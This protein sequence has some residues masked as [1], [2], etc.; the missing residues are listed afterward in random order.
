[1]KKISKRWKIYGILYFTAV[2]ALV[3]ALAFAYIDPSVTT[4]AIQAFAGVAVA[5]GAFF[6]TYG[7]RMKKSWMRTVN[8]DPNDTR[9]TEA[10]LEV[11]R[12]DLQAALAAKRQAKAQDPPAEVK[13]GKKQGNLGGRI[14]TSL[15]CGI[16][17]ALAVILRPMVSFYLSN[18]REFWF[19][20]TDVMPN[21]LLLFFGA[22]AAAAVIHFLLPDGKKL[23]F[24][25]LFAVLAAAGTLCAFVQDHFMSSYLPTLTGDEIDWSI[26]GTWNLLSIGLWAGVF[27]L[28]ILVAVIRPRFMKMTV[29]GLLALL[30]CAEAVN[31]TVDAATMGSEGQ[32]MGTYFTEKGMFET[33]EAGN[34]VVLVSDTFEGTFMNKI[35]ED[36]PEYREML[37]DVTYYENVTG[38][39]VFTYFSYAKFMTGI[40]FPLGK[41]A[42]EGV[43]ECFDR[44]TTIDLIRNK[45]W[46]LGYYNDFS[47]SPSVKDKF[48]NYSDEELHP[49]RQAAWSLT[50]LLLRGSLFR[51]VPQ[52]V[53]SRF[54]VYTLEF[55]YVKYQM[56]D[57]C[58]FIEND[59][60]YYDRLCR[61]GL[62]TV[63]GNPRYNITMLYGVHD[64]CK[65]GYDFHYLENP[66]DLTVEERKIQCARAQLLLLRTYLDQ[67][68]EAGTYDQTTV[69]MMADHGFNQRFYP[70]FLVKEAHRSEEG[71]RVDSTPISVQSDYEDILDA[72]TDGKSFT[73]AIEPYAAEPNRVRYALDFRSSVYEQQTTRRSVVEIRG[74]AK[75]PA[76]FAIARDEFYLDNEFEGR[77]TLDTPFIERGNE[78]HTAAL[79]GLSNGYAFGHSILFDAFFENEE[80]RPMVFRAIVA[81]QMDTAQR[82]QV[83]L[84]GGEVLATF[85]LEAHASAPTEIVVP[86]PKGTVSRQTVRLDMPDAELQEI[87]GE[88]LTW[89]TY[90]SI[91][92]HTAG[93]Y[94]E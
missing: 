56:L 80:S 43:W 89:N 52:P 82:V 58:P 5:A 23:S 49:N 33:S 8:V 84:E 81:N 48:I 51:S 3:P 76:S 29:Y 35:L 25:L 27:A 9:I 77:C 68:K 7:R 40:D 88:K 2:F 22:A 21:I 65:M 74:E 59:E 64:P 42:M 57:E 24:R 72:L 10:A 66:Q 91:F 86:L 20:L 30:I 61:D 50:K 4:Y 45:G 12:E 34:V 79:Y 11:T 17:P 90:A 13:A 41:D 53:K 39:S 47:P 31:G 18:H 67:L 85:E 1:M 32:K 60:V 46:D 44:Q 73:E 38:V 19:D 54:G 94:S 26:Y 70:V 75:D 93:L 28:F 63:Q 37:S 36:Y 92:V 69:I 71:F 15:L 16:A 14:I 6:A 87:V 55:D 62:K 78:N 83:S